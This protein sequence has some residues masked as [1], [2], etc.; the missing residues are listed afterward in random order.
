L[1]NEAGRLS[2]WLFR[3]VFATI[4]LYLVFGPKIDFG[5]VGPAGASRIL[6]VVLLVGVLTAAR[7]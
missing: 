2:R 3:V 7:S 6:G 4:G 5:T 1:S